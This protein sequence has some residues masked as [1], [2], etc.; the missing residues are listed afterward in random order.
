[1]DFQENT[2]EKMGK[3]ALRQRGL[4]QNRFKLL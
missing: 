2:G 3:N 1:M 4:S